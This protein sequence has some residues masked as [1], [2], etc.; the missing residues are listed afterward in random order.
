MTSETVDRLSRFWSHSLKPSH[1]NDLT[2]NELP[3]ATSRGHLQECILYVN[4]Y[5]N[6][7][8]NFFLKSIKLLWCL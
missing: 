1:M 6:L 7:Y 4:T 3:L 2:V 5:A 8:N